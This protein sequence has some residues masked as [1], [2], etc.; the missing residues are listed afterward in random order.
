MPDV[1]ADIHPVD[2]TDAFEAEQLVKQRYP[3]AITASLSPSV[4]DQ[5][6]IRRLFG[7]WLTKI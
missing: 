1:G 5:E 6:E 2:A 4:P 3:A 7:D